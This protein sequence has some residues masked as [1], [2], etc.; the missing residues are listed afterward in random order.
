MK[1]FLLNSEDILNTVE[2]AKLFVGVA[3]FWYSKERGDETK[4]SDKQYEAKTKNVSMMC[5]NKAACEMHILRQEIARQVLGKGVDIF[6][7]FNGGEYIKHKSMSLKDY[8]F[9]IVIE[10]DIKPYYFTEKI[11]D[12]FAAHTIPIYVGAS[13]IAEFFNEDG[14]IVLSKEEALDM[15]KVLVRLTEKEYERRIPAIIDNYNKVL[16][17]RSLND[18]LYETLK[19]A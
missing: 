8:R 16:K 9:Q 10:N 14:I 4:L 11:T 7:R 5:S 15:E 13:K 19:K 12:C 6:G 18:Y 3:P 2:N 17:Y 1:V